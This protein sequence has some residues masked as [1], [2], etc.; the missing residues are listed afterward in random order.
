MVCVCI[1]IYTYILWYLLY[2]SILYMGLWVVTPTSDRHDHELWTRWRRLHHW[3]GQS[4][5]QQHTY[6]IPVPGVWVQIGDLHLAHGIPQAE[7]GVCQQETL[8]MN[9]SV[10]RVAH[11]RPKVSRCISTSWAGWGSWREPSAGPLH[12]MEKGSILLIDKWV[13]PWPWVYLQMD[14]LF[15]GKSHLFLFRGNLPKRMQIDRDSEGIAMLQH[16]KV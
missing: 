9:R 3:N 6:F 1:Y 13:F 4:L 10:L 12:G 16:M 2:I 5:P 14:G 8:M 15:F 7:G 11:G